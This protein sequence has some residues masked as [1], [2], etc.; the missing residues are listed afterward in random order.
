ML[1]IFGHFVP[2]SAVALGIVEI[3]FMSLALYLLTAPI[4]AG[5]FWQIHV[6]VVP[7]QFSVALSMLAIVS[8]VA[9]GLYNYDVFL[10][11]RVMMIK[12]LLALTLAAP[13]A[14]LAA[15]VLTHNPPASRVDRYSVWFLKT[16][17]VWMS[18]VLATRIIFLRFSDTDIFRRRV[19]ILGTGARAARIA[20][21]VQRDDNRYFM[22]TAF[23]H[24]CGDVAQVPG[25][26]LDLDTVE[27]DY[28]LAKCAR[29]TGAREVVVATDDR[30]GM[31]ISQLLHCKIAGV[32]VVDYLTFWERENGKV[33]IDALQPSWLIYSDGFRQG[34]IVDA[35]KRALDVGASLALL[36]FALPLMVAAAVAIRLEGP[37]PMLYRQE[38]V[39]RNGKTFVLL[40]FRSMGVDAERNGAQWAATSDP[41]V[42]RVGGL[43]RK[44]RI[45]ELPQLLNVLRGDMSF[46]GPRPERPVFVDQLARTIPFYGERHSVKPGITGWAQVNYPYGASLDDAR[47]KL[48]FDL[49]Y[50]KNRTLFLDLVILVQTVRVILFSEGAR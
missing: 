37:G 32:N 9:V 46:V 45:D 33:D 30:R 24:A 19:I 40:K 27:D 38:R 3:V 18:C 11:T 44:F 2:V 15:L 50:V 34:V 48:S 29:S 47:Q 7:A 42:T 16:T 26:A 6:S 1:R 13:V 41:R 36:I 21:L 4:E 49:Y 10:D 28:A 12:I 8:M 20:D 39:G 22:P 23:V 25:A 5:H 43:L 35:A 14:A 31:P 17:F